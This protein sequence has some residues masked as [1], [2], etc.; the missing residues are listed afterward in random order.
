MTKK[1]FM[2]LIIR[3]FPNVKITLIKTNKHKFRSL[4]ESKKRSYKT[5]NYKN[6]MEVTD[7]KPLLL[8]LYEKYSRK[9]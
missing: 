3:F 7:G 6:I 2:N 8:K 9:M 1:S 4:K 5:R